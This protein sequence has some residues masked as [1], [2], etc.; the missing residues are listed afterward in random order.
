M[1]SINGI[2]DLIQSLLKMHQISINEVAPP[3]FGPDKKHS[4]IYNKVKSKYKD[5]PEKAYATMWKIHNRI[6]K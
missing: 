6:D 3:E 5:N 4:N 2:D 1:K